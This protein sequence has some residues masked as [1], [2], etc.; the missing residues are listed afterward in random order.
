M[1]FSFSTANINIFLITLNF[2]DAEKNTTNI[3]IGD[4]ETYQAEH[5]AQRR[6]ITIYQ[7]ILLGLS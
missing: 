4:T 2:L 7:E 3:G 6:F 1:L 5:T